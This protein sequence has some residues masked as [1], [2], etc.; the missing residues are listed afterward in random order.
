MN[1]EQCKEEKGRYEKFQI[2]KNPKPYK[3]GNILCYGLI[4]CQTCLCV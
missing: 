4:K 1:L 2:K 3:S